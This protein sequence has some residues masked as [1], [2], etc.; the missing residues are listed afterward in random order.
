MLP[1]FVRQ[2]FY[3]AEKQSFAHIARQTGIPYRTVLALRTGKLDLSS[4]FRTSMRNMFQREAY[5]RLR[6]AGLSASESRRWSWYTPSQNVIKETE[7][8]AAIS[9]MTTGAVARRLEVLGLPTTQ[10][11]VDKYFDELH[12]AITESVR[13]SRKPTEDIIEHIT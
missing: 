1:L 12:Q 4:Q 5:G 8:K 13:K 9:E 11:N 3:I 7:V 2:L 10:A 6:Q